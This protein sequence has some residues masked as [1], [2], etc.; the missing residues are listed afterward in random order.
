VVQAGVTTKPAIQ[1]AVSTIGPDR[2]LGVVL[3]GTAAA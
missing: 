1:D 3:N 2:V